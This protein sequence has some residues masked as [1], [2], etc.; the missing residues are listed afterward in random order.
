MHQ[1]D[2]ALWQSDFIKWS[3]N[4]LVEGTLTVRPLRWWS[5]WGDYLVLGWTLW[6][7]IYQVS[8]CTGAPRSLFLSLVSSFP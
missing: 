5:M 4:D 6:A 1:D 2:F 7:I 3:F 8:S